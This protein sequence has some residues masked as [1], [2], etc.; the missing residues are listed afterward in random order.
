MLH[1]SSSALLL[2]P[3]HSPQH[4][5][6]TYAVAAAPATCQ[7]HAHVRAGTHTQADSFTPALTH[8]IT[9]YAVFS[10]RECPTAA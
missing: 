6:T 7:I 3:H 8:N 4:S 1:D 2:C 9:G 5:R 10:E